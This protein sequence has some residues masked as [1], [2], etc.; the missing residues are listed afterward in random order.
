M[1]DHERISGEGA[2]GE[3]ARNHRRMTFLI[4]QGVDIPSIDGKIEFRGTGG[5]LRRFI[6][7]MVVFDIIANV[8]EALHYLGKSGATGLRG[9]CNCLM[10][11]KHALRQRPAH[12]WLGPIN[13]L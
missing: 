13:L 12:F 7:N 3:C 5:S 9:I 10:C 6:G 4:D 8:D 2:T 1:E 11:L